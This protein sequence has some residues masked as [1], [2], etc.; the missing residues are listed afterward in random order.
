MAL[1][2]TR[3]WLAGAL[4]LTLLCPAVLPYPAM[5]QAAPAAKRTCHTVVKKVHGKKRKVRVC[6]A[7]KSKPKKRP[8]K[9]IQAR[10]ISIPGRPKP[11]EEW[12]RGCPPWGH[13]G[14]VEADLLRNRI[15]RASH[16]RT[17]SATQ[18][19]HLAMPG[20]V[21]GKP[22]PMARWTRKDRRQAFRY[23]GMSASLV[24]YLVAFDR[25]GPSE[26]CNCGGKAGYD[27]HLWIGRSYQSSRK[28]SIITE[29]TPRVRAR[30]RGFD[31]KRFATIAG[32]AKK[33]RVTGWIFLDNDHRV[34]ETDR[35]TLWE[36]HPITR[37][38]VWGKHGW[39]RVAG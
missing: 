30:E 5:G 35:S 33:V 38:E 22:I 18:F 14:D 23:E 7:V 37:L 21:H 39:T 8:T 25:L 29:A 20:V 11:R 12:Y 19:I 34:G 27:W 16:P 36:I 32:G 3:A 26:P 31:W 9:H 17:F 2:T 10:S 6:K 15:D 28:A 1:Q 4:L 24:G 13:G